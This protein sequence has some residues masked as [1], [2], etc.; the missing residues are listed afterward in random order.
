MSKSKIW[1][2]NFNNWNREFKDCKGPWKWFM[3]RLIK[4]WKISI[5]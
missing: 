5:V 4:I 1:C 3:K 2:R